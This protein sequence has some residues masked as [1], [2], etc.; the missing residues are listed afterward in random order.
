MDP[1]EFEVLSYAQAKGRFSLS[2]RNP[3]DTSRRRPT[4]G[5]DLNAFLDNRS[6]ASAS[7]GGEL[8]V[9]EGGKKKTTKIK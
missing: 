1:E 4:K 6:I 5:V 7:G 3:N 8:E 9:I 2:L